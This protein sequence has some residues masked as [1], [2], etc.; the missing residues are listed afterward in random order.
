MWEAI[1][2]AL[3]SSAVTSAVLG[4]IGKAWLESRLKASI[5]HEYKKQF[6]IFTR[7]LN[8]KERV[9]LVAELMAEYMKTPHGE[10][11]ERDQRLL[12]NKL[13]FKATLWLPAEL[14][15]ELGKR[16]QN[17]KDAKSPFDLMLVARKLLI[18]E[19]GITA[20]DITWWD[21]GQETRTPPVVAR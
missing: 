21:P 15:V 12:L 8:R 17:K 9:E 20:D 11:L 2:A 18:G 6:E 14:A 5:E 7:E 16:L 1:V 3:V 19:G 10:K 13:S 4:A